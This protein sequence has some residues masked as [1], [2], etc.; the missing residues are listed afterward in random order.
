MTLNQ[1]RIKKGFSYQQ[2]A[3]FLGIK[4]SPA[5]TVLDGLM[6]REFQKEIQ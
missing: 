4:G 6:V 2:L 1:Y 5:S 3:A